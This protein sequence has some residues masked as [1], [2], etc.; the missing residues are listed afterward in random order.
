M[1]LNKIC[2]KTHSELLLLKKPDFLAFG[3]VHT[4]YGVATLIA[5]S[6]Y[7]YFMA[8]IEDTKLAQSF[9]NSYFPGVISY[10][11]DLFL[12]KIFSEDSPIISP[13]AIGSSF[14]IRVWKA[15]I[16]INKGKTASYQ[17]IS[18]LIHQ[19]GA[20]RAVGTALK[21]NPIAYFI[22]CHRILPKSKEVGNYRWGSHQKKTL[23]EQ[24]E[25]ELL[26]AKASLC[27]RISTQR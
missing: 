23:L 17:D 8:L 26:E 14:Q 16:T 7:L 22:P 10:R 3:I 6:K 2:F 19:P 25:I 21:N 18:R 12:E 27:A 1:I 4:P 15:A 9:I 13:L 20:S 24:E 11:D 5:S